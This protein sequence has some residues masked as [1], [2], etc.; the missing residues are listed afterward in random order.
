MNKS[1]V[2]FLNIFFILYD[3]LEFFRITFDIIG[4]LYIFAF[5]DGADSKQPLTRP[6]YIRPPENNYKDP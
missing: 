3:Y 4:N 5:V 2:Y 1:I 6:I